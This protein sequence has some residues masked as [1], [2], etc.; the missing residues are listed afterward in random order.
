MMDD[1]ALARGL[2]A[3]AE[4]THRGGG[5]LEEPVDDRERQLLR[6]AFYTNAKSLLRMAQEVEQRTARGGDPTPKRTRDG[7][8]YI[9]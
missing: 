8:Q 7:R 1:N 9:N 4:L 2:R 3:I 6:I 5:L